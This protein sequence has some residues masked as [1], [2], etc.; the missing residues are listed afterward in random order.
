MIIFLFG[1]SGCGKGHLSKMIGKEFGARVIGVS[2]HVKKFGIEKV[3]KDPSL[4]VDSI[5]SDILKAGQD[6]IVVEGIRQ[7]DIY[8]GLTEDCTEPYKGIYIFNTNNITNIIARDKVD[9][10]EAEKKIR[11]D[12]ELNVKQMQTI[13]KYMF[14]NEQNKQSDEHFLQLIKNG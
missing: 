14:F 4:V 9:I 12:K 11:L 6:I 10:I 5:K 8:T 2:Y 3:Q 1:Y 13:S 7:M